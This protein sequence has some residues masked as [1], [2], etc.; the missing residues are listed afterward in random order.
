MA[1]AVTAAIGAVILIGY[2][3]LIAAKLSTVPL[4]IV[5]LIGLSLML[6]AFWVDDWKPLFK[7]NDK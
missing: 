4:W 5:S 6:W 3:A 7:R 1:D 2:I